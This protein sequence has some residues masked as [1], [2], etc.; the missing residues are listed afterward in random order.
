MNRKDKIQFLKKLYHGSK[1][2]MMKK[3]SRLLVIVL[4]VFTQNINAQEIEWQNT[5]GGSGSD[6]MYSIQ[7]TVDGGYILGGSSGSNI[8]GDKTEN[9]NGGSDYWIVKSDASGNLQWQSTIGGSLIEPFSSIQQTFDG[10]YI[11]GGSSSS[12][13][14]G[15]KTENSN[16]FYDYWIVKTDSTGNILWQNTI[17]GNG[18]DYL[19][20]I[21]QTADGGYILGGRSDS[22]ISGDKTENSNGFYDYWIVKT[23]SS[24]NIQWQ[25]TLGGFNQEY[26]NSIQQT[27]DGGYILGGW[28]NSYISG[29]ITENNNGL[30][31][32]WIVK[33]DSSGNIQWQNTIG[34][35]GYD[36]LYSIEQTFD[37]GYILGGSSSSDISGD[38]TENS[39]GFDDY[40]IIKTDSSGNIQWQ[41]TL[42]GSW[43]D[44]LYSIRQTYDGGYFLG[45]YSESNTSGDKTENSNGSS[46]YWIVKTDSTGNMQ[47]QNTIGGIDLEYL[48]SIQQTADGGFILGG[49]SNSNISGDKSE[50]SQGGVD[51][52]IIKV[53]NHY[54][55][56]SG[57]LFVDTNSNN[58]YDS[59][60]P[61]IVNKQVT[62]SVTGRFSFSGQNGFYNISV[63]DSGN[64]SVSPAF[65]NFYNQNPLMHTAYFP[66][67]QLTDS[68]NDFAFQPAG[69]FNDLCASIT[70]MG[71]FR[72]GFDA[73]YMINYEN[74]GTTTL[75]PTIIFFPDNDVSFVS[76]NVNP[77]SV[78]TDSVV[79]VLGPLTPFQ[80]GSILVTVNVNAGTPIGTL[81]NSGVRI[82]PLAG[83]ANT[84]CNSSYWEIFTTGSVDPNDILVDEDTLFTT[85]FPNPPLLEYIIRFQNTGNDT[86]FI[87]KVLN[88]IDTFNLQLNTFE[89]VSS[90]HPVNINWIPWERN[91]EF[92]F[93]NI[94][95][96]DSTIN[97]PASHGFI[98]YR[99][100][101]KSTL[102]AGDSIT[103]NAAIYF[104][105]NK[106][107]LTNTALTEV[108]LPTGI[109]STNTELGITLAP[110]PTKDLVTIS[111][112]STQKHDRMD[113]AVFD[114]FGRVVYKSTFNTPNS[115]F[116]IDVSEFSNG[117]YFIKVISSERNACVK[118]IKQ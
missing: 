31:D 62:E 40:W 5:I 75:S 35:S 51:Y 6:G 2:I 8:S 74:V 14:S 52:W 95:L 112:A 48:N 28:S 71:N 47:W 32:Y 39:N 103:N 106:P 26:L 19:S 104:D 111:F 29:D 67:I 86:A 91:M 98:R 7:Q 97:E 49:H 109:A 64:Y 27:A 59:G 57:K 81:I 42:G 21:Q 68:L 105:F 65:I 45:G 102:V 38:K 80:S 83:D 25:N 17:G 73:S 92:K 89:F 77:T 90:S 107:V 78:T 11:L 16:G 116:E 43:E 53:T 113:L 1:L 10:G 69:V 33:T 56:I 58:L 114:L 66:G 61:A 3:L 54:N 99:I 24:G 115:T 117:V 22:N 34:G 55:L 36:Q 15:D 72:A 118:F 79:W 100:R 63:L 50:N 12:D 96:P 30:N 82:E 20:S 18:Y 23:D 87:V 76:S 13:I 9:S 70:P 41:N 93:E 108:L 84:I 110:N 37:G 85:Q 101:P 60:E 4:M 88:P 46:D 44:F 94:L